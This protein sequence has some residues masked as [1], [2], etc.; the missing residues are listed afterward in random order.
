MAL[1][2][3]PA[4]D[5]AKVSAYKVPTDT[6]ES[7]GTLQ[8]DSTILVL[9]ELAAGGVTGLGYSYADTATARL[10]QDKLTPLL[11][12]SD[13]TAIPQI[14]TTLLNALRN[15]GQTGISAMAVSAVDNAL[16]DLKAK[17][18]GLSVAGLLGAVRSAIPAYASGG[19]TSYSAAQLQQQVEEWNE[20]GFEF[21]KIKVGRQPS[22]DIR[23]V[24]LAREKL[25][26][27]VEL[28][29]DANGAYTLKQ[30]LQQADA[31]AR[32][33][34]TWF[35]EPV[36][37]NNLDGL[38]ILRMRSP[39]GMNISAGEYGYDPA[40]FTRMLRAAAVDVLQADATRCA[41]VTGFM[42]AAALCEGFDMPLSSH[43][44]PA[45]HVHTC[46]AARPACHVEYFYD[47][48]RIENRL[49]DGVTNPVEG[50]L[51]PAW[52]RPGFGL[53]FKYADA[54]KYAV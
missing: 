6:P 39:A 12:G 15:L 20:Q 4:I 28:F 7:D 33:G 3:P 16:W 43:C 35:E 26:D 27:R 48:V 53:E 49:F 13:P 19:F 9:V 22:E 17:L 42:G 54:R 47:H 1:S 30:A 51:S 37:S 31:F 44:A 41:G 29:V 38:N 52:H 5:A 21:V 11:Q 2:R 10:I 40:Y 8:W 36:S 45:L 24:A 46:C 50:M 34:V 23:R 14:R 32:Y 18:M 25:A